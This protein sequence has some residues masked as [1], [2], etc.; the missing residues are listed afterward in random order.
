M[1][2]P[3]RSAALRLCGAILI[4]QSFEWQAS[5]R[6]YIKMFGFDN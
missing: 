4:D 3:D 6:P 5:N 2:F 1:I